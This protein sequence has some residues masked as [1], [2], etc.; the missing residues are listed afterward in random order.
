[1]NYGSVCSGIEAATLAWQPLNWQAKFF[2]EVEP[3]PS[4]V[5]QLNR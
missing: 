2:A 3:F 1:M 5:L 4:A